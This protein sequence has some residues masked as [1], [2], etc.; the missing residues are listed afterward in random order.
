M[1][2]EGLGKLKKIQLPQPITLPFSSTKERIF[3]NWL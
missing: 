2:L 1:R 3:K